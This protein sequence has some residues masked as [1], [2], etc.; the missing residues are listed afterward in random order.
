[1]RFGIGTVGA[2]GFGALS[3]FRALPYI[4]NPNPRVHCLGFWGLRAQSLG[5]LYIENVAGHTGPTEF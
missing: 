2:S 1:M 5:F 4:L 3:V